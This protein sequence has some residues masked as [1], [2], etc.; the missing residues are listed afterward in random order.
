MKKIPYRE[1]VGRLTYLSKWIKSNINHAVSR[2]VG[3]FGDYPGTANWTVV[4][5]FISLGFWKYGFVSYAP[6]KLSHGKLCKY[7]KMY[8]R[9]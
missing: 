5:L 2:I 4:K 7:R 8:F 9:I 1:A 6:D 3:N